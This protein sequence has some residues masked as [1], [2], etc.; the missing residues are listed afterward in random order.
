MIQ[1]FNVNKKEDDKKILAISILLIFFVVW[2]C[3]PPGNKIAQLCFFGSHTQYFIAKFIKRSDIDEWKF[4]RNNAVYLAR[5]EQQKSSL[6]EM[7]K[8]IKTIPAFA[9]D[10]ELN[11]L[12]KDRAKLRLYWGDLKGAL[13]DYLRLPTLDLKDRL[14]IALLYKSQGKNKYAISYC[15]SILNTTPTAYAG[16]ACVA[17]VY[18]S[19]GK[20]DTSVRIFDLL[21]DKSP[22]NPRY[23]LDRAEYKKLCG[24]EL[25]ANADI[26]KAKEISP[27]AESKTTLIHDTLYPKHLDLSII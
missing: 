16:Y 21:I 3:T 18:A 13:D 19:V 24:D 1:N 22:N 5:M 6:R 11:S 10:R 17:D 26:D 27:Y 2:L 25:G 23:Y 14:T 7:D 15:N 20:F 8:A 12:Y 4:H 9:S